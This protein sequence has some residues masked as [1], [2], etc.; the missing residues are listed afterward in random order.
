M[1]TPENGIQGVLRRLDEML[2]A[3]ELNRSKGG[4]F[5]A[6]YRVTTAEVGRQVDAGSFE[7]GPRMVRLDVI[8]AGHYLR[9][10]RAWEKGQPCPQPWK[11]AFEAESD[12]S[13]TILQ[14]LLLGMN[15]HIRY[16]LAQAV[17]QVAE[18]DMRAIEADF[19]VLNR[20][21][22]QMIDQ[23][24]GAIN[25]CSP[26][27]ELVDTLGLVLD[28]LLARVGIRHFRDAAWKDALAL[29]GREQGALEEME[30]DTVRIAGVILDL[31]HVLGPLRR[32]E[33]DHEAPEGVPT[34]I[35]ALRASFPG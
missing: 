17:V 16:D 27:M 32:R 22:A 13:V 23:V 3:A 7:D 26:G 31:S 5:P 25:R 35:R 28:E 14:H 29:A 18:Q 6:L 10:R 15:A 1:T 34:V 33:I 21:L 20:I 9:A 4:Y 2:D 24:Q 11:L 19:M 12:E 30:K 8:F